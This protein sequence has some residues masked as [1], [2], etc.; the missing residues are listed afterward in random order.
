MQQ[1]VSSRELMVQM[2]SID[3]D[4]RDESVTECDEIPQLG[5]SAISKKI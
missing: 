3:V 4:L 2:R 5:S 1:A